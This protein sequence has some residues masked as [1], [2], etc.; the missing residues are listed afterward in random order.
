MIQRELEKQ[1]T[2]K[3]FR[4]KVIV[5]IGARQTGKTTLVK[6]IVKKSGLD[7]IWFSGDDYITREELGKH[8]I[9]HLKSLV[10][11]H[12][13]VIIDEAQYINNI[14]LTLKIMAD[15]IPGIQVIATGSSS[16]DLLNAVNEPLTGRKWEY[17]LFPLSY[18]E[19]I[20]HYDPISEKGLL[21]HRLIFGSYPEIVEKKGNE[22]E[23]LQLLTSNYLYKDLLI[24]EQIKK[25]QII[26]KLV[27]A[28]AFQVSNEVSYG[29]LAQTVGADI[30]TIEKYIDMLEKAFIVFRLYGLSRNLRNEIKKSRK[31]YF[32][33]NG[34]R[35][36]VIGNFSPVSSRTDIGAL[37]ENY[38]ISERK[39]FLA[40]ANDY[41]NC[42]FWRTHAQQEIDY[43]E[44]KDG[45]LKAFEIKWNP[46]KKVKFPA[47]FLKA[48]PSNET[49]VVH[50]GNFADFLN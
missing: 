37:W 20:N 38:F 25:P 24:H 11:N 31:I 50:P 6:K 29:E 7:A 23:L 18:N 21:N 46:L 39:K 19:L 4:G 5:L 44:E 30:Q 3:F 8:S 47:S 49:N 41:S 16:F 28:L 10:G 9:S 22:H 27:R 2:S 34:I 26:E 42:Y 14:G 35:N 45:I 17:L 36:T 12:K 48:Y 40:Y 33:D 43:I 1:L 15:H 13:L 32:Y